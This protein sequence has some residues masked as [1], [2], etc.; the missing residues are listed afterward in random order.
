MMKKMFRRL[1]NKI[2]SLHEIAP[3]YAVTTTIVYGWTAYWSLN[4]LP[5]WLNYLRLSEIINL[6]YYFLMVNFL[7]SIFVSLFI[8]M[9]CVLLPPNWL[10][11]EFVYRGTAL[12]V[13]ITSYLAAMIVRRS[14]IMVFSAN[15]VRWFPLVFTIAFIAI[16]LAGR[17]SVL[18]YWVEELADRATV[19]LYFTIPISIMAIVI[20]L[21]RALS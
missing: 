1:G 8:V 4:E 5:A 13:F 21:F 19:F 7:E 9:T 11:S 16:L 17:I 10:L 6:F 15:M 3:V 2:P 12:S 20:I 14:Q 18:K